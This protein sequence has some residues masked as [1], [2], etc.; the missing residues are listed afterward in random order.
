MRT[1]DSATT[2]CAIAAETSNNVRKIENKSVFDF[3]IPFVLFVTL[4]DIDKN[5]NVKYNNKRYIIVRRLYAK[6]TDDN[7]RSHDR[8]R[9]PVDPGARP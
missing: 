1:M 9:V 3:D 7:K 4:F 8:R 6:E 5:E 2:S